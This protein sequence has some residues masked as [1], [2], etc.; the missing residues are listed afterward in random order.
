[1]SARQGWAAGAALAL[2]AG[3]SF[4]TSG[5]PFGSADAFEGCHEAEGILL[6]LDSPDTFQL[7]GFLGI[8]PGADPVH[9]FE[10]RSF[11]LGGEAVSDELARL[12]G[13]LAGSPGD[14]VPITVLR[15]VDGTL[16]LR[17]A[18]DPPLG[19]LTECGLSP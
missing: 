15:A 17:I 12:D 8:A 16:T 18:A 5:L 3:C 10:Q 6:G 13:V 14:P 11:A 9:F 2:V 4:D 19:P 7:A 1:M